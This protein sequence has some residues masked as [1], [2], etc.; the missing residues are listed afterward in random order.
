MI[1]DEENGKGEDLGLGG[2]LSNQ[3]KKGEG[4]GEAQQIEIKMEYEM[5]DTFYSNC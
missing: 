5:V 3:R 1:D 2:K 4:G